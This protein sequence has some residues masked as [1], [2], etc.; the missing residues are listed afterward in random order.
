MDGAAAVLVAAGAG[1]RAGA[2]ILAPE[3]AQRVG[4]PVASLPGIGVAVAA[5]RT[6]RRHTVRA[7]SLKNASPEDFAETLV[8]A[9]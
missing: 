1:W 9:I 3:L 2:V 4:C 8:F 6:W 7:A 5:E